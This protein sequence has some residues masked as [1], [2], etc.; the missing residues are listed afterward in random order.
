MKHAYRILAGR[1]EKKRLIEEPE[2]R[3]EDN[4]QTDL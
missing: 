1:P 3:W 2:A 4:I